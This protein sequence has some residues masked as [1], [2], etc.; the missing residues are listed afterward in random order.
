VHVFDLTGKIAVVTGA[1]SGIGLAA[2]RRFTAAGATVVLADLADGSAFAAE[3]GGR[4]VRTDVS[5][6]ADVRALMAA[7]AEL[8]GRID[9]CVNNAGISTAAPLVE[10]EEVDAERHFRVHT[11]GALFGMKHAAAHMPPGS[12]I[13]NTASI[14]GVTSYPTCGAYVASKF[15]VVGLTK[16]AALELGPRGIRVNCV[17]PT[18]VDTAMLSGQY[19]AASEV[20]VFGTLGAS[21]NLIRAEEVAAAM[22]FLVAD[23]CGVISG[24]AL[25]LDGAMTSGVSPRLLELTDATLAAG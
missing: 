20:A 6:E 3:L 21:R 22:H 24:H 14:L 9:I 17:C 23:D 7:A 11:L 25:I 4:Y 2:A 8:E 5:V 18:S 19:N 13:V 12:A 1:A 15:G 16:T 10:L